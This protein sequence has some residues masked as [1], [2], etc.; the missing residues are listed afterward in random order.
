MQG[1]VIGE[2]VAARVQLQ[3]KG[4][5]KLDS[6]SLDSR[7]L[8]RQHGQKMGDGAKLGLDA[9]MDPSFLTSLLYSQAET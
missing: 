4:A 3:R 2:A 9:S 7:S 5:W 1:E 6:R 8:K